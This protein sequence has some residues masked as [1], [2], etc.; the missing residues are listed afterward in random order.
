MKNTIGNNITMTLFG[1]SH[2]SAIGAVLDGVPS[3]IKV[4][5]D[6]IQA[7]MEKRKAKGSISTSRKEADEVEILSGVKDG[8]TEGTPI[9]ILV[10]NTNVRKEDYNAMKNIPRPSHA[11]YSGHMKYLGYEDQSGGGHFSGRLTAPIVACGAIL[12]DMLEEKGI[13]IQTHIKMLHGIEDRDFENIEE[14]MKYLSTCDFAVLD[15]TKKDEMLKEIENARSQQD[16]VGGILETM[17]VGVGAGIGEPT[18][19]TV[20]GE[21]SK[22][23]FSIGGIKGVEFGSGFALAN[24]F[25]SQANDAFTVV[26]GKVCTTTNHSG[27]INGGITNGMPIVMRC[28]VKPT[29]SI[30]KAQKSVNLETMEEVELSIQGRHDPAIIHRARVVVDSMCA[31]VLCDLLVARYGTLYFQGEKK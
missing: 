5:M 9:A 3:G 20:E 16:S 22:A 6:H 1:E 12:M 30:A 18:F 24:M 7:Q 25:G 15:D 23:M 28:V 11:D 19:D 27:G 31:L 10:R 14:D 13:H 2:G 17:I 29:A 8:Y 4:N 21:L 26:D